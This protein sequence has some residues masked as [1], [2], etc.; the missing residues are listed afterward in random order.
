MKRSGAKIVIRAR[1]RKTP[2][3]QQSETYENEPVVE[4][5]AESADEAEAGEEGDGAEGASDAELPEESAKEDQD[6]GVTNENV[7]SD[8]G[9]GAEEPAPVVRGRGRGRPRG[10]GR[11]AYAGTGR[12]RGRP[13]GSGRGRGRPRGRGGVTLRIP[14]RGSDGEEEGDD[15]RAATEDGDFAETSRYRRSA[16]A[17]I[18]EGMVV[19]GDAYVTEED[20]KGNEKIDIN[21]NLLGGER[22]QWLTFLN[23]FSN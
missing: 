14:R 7:N 2:S 11:A 22:L 5:P 23:S 17:G 19:E 9:S 18:P 4:Q 13:R 8:V 6:D 21:G 1:R 3:D 15:S 16:A 10:S 12:P 20:P